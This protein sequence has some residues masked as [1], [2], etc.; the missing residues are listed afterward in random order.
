MRKLIDTFRL[1][2]A[3]VALAA[4]LA[5]PVLVVFAA[6]P[7]TWT[8]P[9]TSWTTGEIVTAT[10]FNQ[11]NT[12]IAALG[13]GM[14][15]TNY[16]CS[17]ADVTVNNSTALTNVTGAAIAIGSNE[18]WLFQAIV[19][20]SSNATADFDFAF[21]GP[22]APTALRYSVTGQAPITTASAAFNGRVSIGS[23]GI[24]IANMYIVGGYVQNAGTAGTIQLRFSQNVA[25]VADTIVYA[26]TCLYG[27][28]LL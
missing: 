4:L 16:G 10:T 19:F 7:G 12:N 25:T 21:S 11:M 22:A 24:T 23:N 8:T 1:V 13:N 17:S 6:A 3:G 15:G 18:K 14:N 9:D 27:W 5:A 26:Q 2:L 28:R 20:G